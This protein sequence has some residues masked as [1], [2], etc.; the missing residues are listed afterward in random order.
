MTTYTFRNRKN[1]VIRGS[2]TASSD[3]ALFYKIDVKADP[4][5]FEYCK[6]TQDTVWF[7]EEPVWLVFKSF[8]TLKTET[9]H[10][11]ILATEATKEIV[12]N[13]QKKLSEPH[14][15]NYTCFLM[16]RSHLSIGDLDGALECI[17]SDIDKLSFID[18]KLYD[19]VN[20]LIQ[21]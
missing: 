12:D 16:A 11:L 1:K 17:R 19:Y 18:K 14:F 4:F 9:D 10:T 3:N 8:L 21:N 5:S 13:L 7:D 2:V 20:Y 15:D 6:T